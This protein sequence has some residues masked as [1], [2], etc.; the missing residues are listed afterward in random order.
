MPKLIVSMDGVVLKEVEL[1]QEQTTLGRR[2]YND[3]VIDNLAISGEHAVVHKTGNVVEIEDLDSTNHTYVNGKAVQRQVLC[4]GDTV[5]VG[6]YKIRFLSEEE[7]RDFDKTMLFRPGM[8]APP[9][10]PRPVAPA[11]TP[12]ATPPAIPLMRVLSGSAAGREVV[13]TKVVTTLGKP[14]VAVASV[15]RRPHGFVLAYVE[16]AD[17]PTLNNVPIGNTAVPLKNG[18]RLVLAGTE[19][20]FVQ[21]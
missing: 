4:H 13:L 10:V 12:A 15:T 3:I 1:T 21:G 6:K 7:G 17:M 14:G 2:P 19:M 16:G 9:L 8:V 5:E 18:D 20:Q 11:A